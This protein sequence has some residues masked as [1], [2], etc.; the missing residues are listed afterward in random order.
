M[1]FITN[2]KSV[3]IWIEFVLHMHS[4]H[5]AEAQ[6]LA[7]DLFTYVLQTGRKSMSFSDFL[8]DPGWLRQGRFW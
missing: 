7:A 6:A 3:S 1:C 8:S 5:D 2:T 4:K